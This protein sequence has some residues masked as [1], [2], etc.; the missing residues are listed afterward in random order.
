MT[1][2]FNILF[3]LLDAIIQK[4][5]TYTVIYW[6]YRPIDLQINNS[7]WPEKYKK[8]LVVLSIYQVTYFASFFLIF[9]GRFV[10]LTR[11]TINLPNKLSSRVLCLSSNTLYSKPEEISLL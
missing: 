5:D 11:R 8:F 7:R 2:S 3:S 1:I 6:Q 10:T 9:L 4:F